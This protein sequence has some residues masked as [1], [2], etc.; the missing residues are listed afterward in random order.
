MQ[1]RRQED[2]RHV[3]RRKIV[4][5]PSRQVDVGNRAVLG[6]QGFGH[7]G[8]GTPEPVCREDQALAAHDGSRDRGSPIGPPR[9]PR[10][11]QVHHAGLDREPS[12]RVDDLDRD[13]RAPARDDD[14]DVMVH[15]HE[16][17]ITR[18]RGPVGSPS[19]SDFIDGLRQT[20]AASLFPVDGDLSL[21]GLN[22]PVEVRRD[23]WGVPYLEAASLDD[24]W[25]AQG[26][27][28]A[29]ERLFQLDLLLR[30]ANGR[31]SEV[32]ADRTLAE[33]RFAR[34]VGFHHAGAKMAARWND[35][36]H[37]MH[38]RFRDGV[39]AW[40]DAMPAPPVEYTLLDLRP[41]LPVDEASWAAAFAFLAW[42]LSGNWDTELLRTW[43]R[44][45]AGD[46]AVRTL[47]PP[48][49]TDAPE[50]PAGALNGALFDAVPRS[51]GQGSNNWVVAGSRTASGKPLLANDPHLLA[52]QP[53]AWLE[54]HLSAPGYRV[55]GVALTFSPGV[56]L[57]TTEHH[58][59]GVTNVSGD[60]QDLYI[61]RLSEDGTASLFEDAWAP[62]TTRREEIVVRGEADP[63]VVDVRATLHGPILDTFLS[64]ILGPDHVELAPEPVFALRW[65]GLEGSGIR[66]SLV[67]DAAQATD[68]DAFRAAVLGVECPGQNFV[69]ADVDGTIGYACTGAFPLR[70]AGDGT[71]PVPGWTAE[72]G[73]DGFVPREE[74]PWGVDPARGFLAT[75]NNRIH[76]D[77]YPFLIGHDFHTAFRA[78]RIVELLAASDAHDVASMSAIQNDTVSLPSRITLPLLLSVTPDSHDTTAALDLLQEWDGDMSADSAAAAVFN[79]WS[80]HIA[81]RTLAPWLG[82]DLFRHYHAW[83]EVFQCEVLPSLLRDRPTSQMDDDLLRGALR[84]ADAELRAS[85][86]DDPTS[87]RWG[88]L[89]RLRLA[90]PLASIPGLEPL[91]VAA[92]VEMGGDEQTVMQGGF[93]GREG[94]PAAVIPS[95]RAVFDLA[96]PD[97]SVGVLPAGISGNPASPHWN[98]QTELWAQGHYHPLPF[99]A[100]AV[101]AA[102]V[103]RM[104][105]TPR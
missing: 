59:W 1:E 70:R 45:R 15:G 2:E 58:A 14:A 41:E 103:T 87:W 86:G 4:G 78:R 34:T 92:D 5:E 42:G 89:H 48:L 64:G 88:A 18:G 17:E 23:T 8:Q 21:D 36:D 28:T 12:Q 96:D 97:R 10:V 38:A 37:A 101:E 32:F 27:L 19:V 95:W 57:G 29:G 39:F 83:R 55:R 49:A 69:Y 3:D 80:R 24:L 63:H 76:D 91:F 33:D 30:A 71:V 40:I 26:V 25:F 61:E 53:G 68:F 11:Q 22:A 20:A 60:V 66:P 100:G 6:T 47:L 44:E 73:W 75:A 52:V 51:S 54:M 85:L 9:E 98:D 74:L 13:E 62:L 72:H 93:D 46:D 94:Y 84:E 50:I 7:I 79:V 35:L 102:T 99:T 90:H 104:R 16:S 105:L 77:A 67:I 82:D 81:R 43:I 31:L 56:L 65:T